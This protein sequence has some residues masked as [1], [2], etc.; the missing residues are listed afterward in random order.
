MTGDA[1]FVEDGLDICV[2]IHLFFWTKKVE[3]NEGEAYQGRKK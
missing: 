2:K 1:V 3:P